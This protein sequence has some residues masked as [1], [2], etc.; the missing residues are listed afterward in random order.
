FDLRTTVHAATAIET[1]L[2]DLLGQFLDVPLCTLL[3]DGR[4]RDEVPVLG[5]LFFVADSG[6]TDLPY[7]Q[8]PADGDDWLR[9]RDQEAMTPAAIVRLAEAA[10]DRYGFADFKL[11]GGVLEPAREAEAVRALAERFPDARITLDPNGAW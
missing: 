9:L 4:Q 6:R 1:A 7:R 11:K 8:P 5:Y 10:R 3:G 2:L